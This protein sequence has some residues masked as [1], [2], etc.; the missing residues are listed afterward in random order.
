MRKFATHYYKSQPNSTSKIL[1][2]PQE[3]KNTKQMTL[4][5]NS[6]KTYNVKTKNMHSHWL[7]VP[8]S[9]GR[10]PNSLFRGCCSVRMYHDSKKSL[11]LNKVHVSSIRVPSQSIACPVSITCSANADT[12]LL[13]LKA[14]F[15][16]SLTRVAN[17]RFV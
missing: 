2:N 11:D 6:F 3:Y 9:E 5:T 13:P 7:K 10:G 4:C 16:C 12:S 15:W 17:D 1:S 14:A 8:Y